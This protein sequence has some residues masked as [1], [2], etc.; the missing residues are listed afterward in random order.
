ME[1]PN[2]PHYLLEHAPWS[3]EA[4][5][6]WPA[7][8][9][10]IRRN[11]SPHLF[12]SKLKEERAQILQ[13]QLKEALI[14][15]A[16]LHDPQF[17]PAENLSAIEK[18]FL[19]EHFLRLQGFQSTLKG[20][21]F[22]VDASARFL[23]LFN[24][25]D[26]LQLHL[27]ECENKL[28]SGWNSLSDL[29]T[30]LSKLLDF[31]FSEK[32]GYLTADPALCG[33]GFKMT[34]FL[35]LPALI[36]KDKLQDALAKQ[37]DEEIEA[38]S[39]QGSLDEHLGDL[40]I[41]SNRFTLGVSEENI[42]YSLHSAAMQFALLEKTLRAHLREDHDSEM[43]DHV[44]RAFGLLMHSYQLQTKETLDALSLMKLGLDLGWISGVTDQAINEVFFLCRRAHL[45][46][47][48]LET[49]PKNLPRRRAELIH[50]KLKPMQ[51]SIE[52]E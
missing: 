24:I 26:H 52:K 41:L 21:G 2:L 48:S 44:S 11:V 6:I 5:P 38:S 36:H 7:T 19:F 34:A 27:T 13:S 25:E 47:L 8:T 51:L 40:L 43:K 37:N 23:A 45:T 14:A 35:H 31:A 20:Q 22:L 29:D 32:F 49:D 18:E 33:T 1:S 16:A 17:L 39:M 46:S 50:T 12:P 30:K 10:V 9:F 28:E 3:P 4:D 42:F 15:Q